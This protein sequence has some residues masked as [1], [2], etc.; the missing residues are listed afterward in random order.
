MLLMLLAALPGPLA[1]PTLPASPPEKCERATFHI[2]LASDM[3]SIHPLSQEP[4]ARREAAVAYSEG[5]CMKP[6]TLMTRRPQP[7]PAQK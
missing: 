1:T 7:L 3:A 2:A 6:V 4:P 5:G